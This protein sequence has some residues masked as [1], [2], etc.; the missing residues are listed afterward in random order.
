MNGVK[1]VHVLITH[2]HSDYIGS[3]GGFI[4]YCYWKYKITTKV[5]FN[6]KDRIKLF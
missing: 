1:E 5:Y 3:L 6:E 4:G 2:M